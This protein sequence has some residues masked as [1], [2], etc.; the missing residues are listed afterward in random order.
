M[1]SQTWSEGACGRSASIT[2]AN[3]P[4]SANA[5]VAGP[6]HQAMARRVGDRAKNGA[7]PDANV[8]SGYAPPPAFS[9]NGSESSNWAPILERLH[10]P[11]CNKF[12]LLQGAGG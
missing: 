6:R 5:D 4:R 1:R 9:M 10:A 11:V 3:R 2:R 7:P 12:P 8:V